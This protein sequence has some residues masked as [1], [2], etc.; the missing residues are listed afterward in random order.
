MQ[1]KLHTDAGNFRAFKALIAAEYNKVDIQIVDV[2]L[3]NAPADF[4]SKSPHG[5]VPVL[6]TM[7]GEYVHESNAIARFIAKLR[8]DSELLGTSLLESAQV[9]SWIDFSSHNI[10]LPSTLWFYPILGYM[11]LNESVSSVAKSDLFKALTVLDNHLV[12]KT[13]VVGHKITL[14]DIAIVSALIY[15]FKFVAD[16]TYRSNFPNVM[17]W[18]TTCVYQKKIMAV[19]GKVEL[20]STEMKAAASGSIIGTKKSGSSNKEKKDK[21]P[22]A[23]KASSQQNKEEV[24]AKDK[25]IEEDAPPPKKKEDHPFKVMDQTK[26]SP[27][28]MDSWKKTYSNCNTY[29][30]AMEIFWNTFDPEGWSIFRGDYNYDEESKV[31]FMTS[32]LIG[33]FIQRT[34]EIRKWL[35]GTMTIRGEEGKLMKITAYYLIRGDSIEPLIK[36]NDDAACYTWTKVNYPFSQ[37]DKSKI[38]EYWTSETS[39]EGEPLLDSRVYK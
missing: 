31:L 9:D 15:P 36:C 24:K 8:L 39:L 34:D 20:A 17:R 4:A 26:K 13:Y 6:E 29:E 3:D 10:E 21:T 11:P 22:K 19:V 16:P 28:V 1:Y 12:D 35:F 14:A 33:G 23:P 7:N 37:E 27:F 18:F 30:E 32:N 2:K 5:K 38:F 25:E